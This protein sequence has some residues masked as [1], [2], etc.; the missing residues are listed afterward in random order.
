MGS[1]TV[2][3]ELDGAVAT[4]TMNRPDALNAL[5]LQLTHDLDARVRQA[6]ADGARC[7][8]VHR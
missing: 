3:Y 7:S 4:V 5:S 2:I 1:E 6:I 8:C